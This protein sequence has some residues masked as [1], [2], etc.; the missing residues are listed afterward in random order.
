MYLRH[1][2]VLRLANADDAI[3][4]AQF[5]DDS[6]VHRAINGYVMQGC[7]QENACRQ[8]IGQGFV[9][10]DQQIALQQATV[11]PRITH[12]HYRETFASFDAKPTGVADS[13]SY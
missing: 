1:G 5:F 2:Y 13:V 11:I 6:D 3:Q 4:R 7:A 12:F 9:S 8:T 10:S